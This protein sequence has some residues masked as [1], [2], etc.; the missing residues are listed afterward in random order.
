MDA[1]RGRLARAGW[2]ERRDGVG[3]KRGGDA[4]AGGGDALGHGDLKAAELTRQ[5]V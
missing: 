1:G 3:E 2:G 4:Y 5:N